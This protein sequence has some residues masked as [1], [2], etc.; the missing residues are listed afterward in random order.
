[1]GETEGRVGTGGASARSSEAKAQNQSVGH[2]TDNSGCEGPAAAEGSSEAQGWTS[3]E[4]SSQSGQEVSPCEG[5]NESAC[6]ENRCEE[7]GSYSR[8]SC[9]CRSV[10]KKHDQ[11]RA[12][13]EIQAHA[14]ETVFFAYECHLFEPSNILAQ[15]TRRHSGARHVVDKLWR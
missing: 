8:L 3:G 12:F 4:D 11:C 6:E 13:A 15:V 1:V 10:G 7:S 9:R 2:E 5:G 14:D